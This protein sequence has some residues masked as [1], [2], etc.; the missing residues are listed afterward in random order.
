MASLRN[1]AIALHRLAGE[2]NIA[3]ATRRC[4]QDNRRAFARLCGRTNRAALDCA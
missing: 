4:C 2:K 1:L 3:S